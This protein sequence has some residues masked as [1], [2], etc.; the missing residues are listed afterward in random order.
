MIFKAGAA[1]IRLDAGGSLYNG[2]NAIFTSYKDDTLGGDCT[3]D[4]PR[5]PAVGDWEGLWIDDGS[6][7][8]CAAPVDS[9]RYAEKSG[10]A[11]LY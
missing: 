1:A 9:I 7:A 3:G 6:K 4:G 10:T 5:P 11:L 2:P 8:D